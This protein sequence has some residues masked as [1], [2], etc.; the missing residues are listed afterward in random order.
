MLLKVLSDKAFLF[1][2]FFKMHHDF[3]I[4]CNKTGPACNQC[5]TMVWVCV[6]GNGGSSDGNGG[7]DDIC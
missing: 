7:V 6:V 1:I 4:S 2:H 5:V 3:E